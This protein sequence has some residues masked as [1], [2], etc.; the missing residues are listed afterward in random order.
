M[1]PGAVA[2]LPPHLFFDKQ[3]PMTT[4]TPIS[5]GSGAGLAAASAALA[6]LDQ[7]SHT[8]EDQLTS[9]PQADTALLDAMASADTVAVE[10]HLDA[11][12]QQLDDYWQSRHTSLAISMEQALR[13]EMTLKVHE[14]D[15]DA[16]YRVC[17]PATAEP[18]PDGPV[19]AF[20]LYVQFNEDNDAEITGALVMCHG[21]GPTLLWLPGVGMLGFASRSAMSETIA[22]W[23]NDSNLRGTVLR[24]AEQH[25]QDIFQTINADPELFLP[26]FQA[27]DVQLQAITGNPFHYSLDRQRHKQ[28]ADVRHACTTGKQATLV[29][30]AIAMRG[31]L[32]PI[33][34]LELRELAY[35][36]ARQRKQLPHWFRHANSAEQQTC[37]QRLQGYDQTRT[38]LL[39][40]MDGATSPQQFADIRLRT[41]LAT[42]LGYDLAPQD[43]IVNTQRTLPLTGESYTVS[44]SLVQL[45]LYGLHPQDRSEGSAF[46]TQTHLSL[47]DA[48]IAADYPL[49]T[50]TYIARLIDELNMRVTFGEIQRRTFALKHKQQLIRELIRKQLGAL[51]YTAWMQGHISQEELAI[52]ESISGQT[53]DPAVKLQLLRLNG[54]DIPSKLLVLRKDDAQGRPERLV[55]F[56]ADAPQ[57]QLFKGFSNETQLLHELVSWS[58]LAPMSDYLV[59]QVEASGQPR[60]QAQLA[61]LRL[62]PYPPENFMQLLT[63]GDYSQGLSALVSEQLRVAMAE[64][65]RHT[66]AWLIRASTE[67]RQELLALEQAAWAAEEHYTGK[68][69]SQVPEFEAY[70]HQRASQKINQLLGLADGQVD[71]DQIIITSERETLSYTQMLR[72]GYDDSLGLLSAGADTLATF[73]GPEGVDLSLLTPQKVAR[74]VHGKWLADDYI[75]QIRSNLL[76]PES[77]GYDY[78]RQTSLLINQLHMQAAALRSLL[79]GHIDAP[80]YQWLRASLDRLQLNDKQTREDFPL[81][82]LQL[83]IDKPFIGSGL[84]G[85]DQLIVPAPVLIHIET[86]QGCFVVLPTRIRQAALLYTPQAPDGVEFRLFADFVTSLQQPGMVD[87]YKD[88]CRLAAR[89]T[90]SFFLND[91]KKGGANKPPFIPREWFSDL[92]EICYNR[93]LERKIRDVEDT[94]TGRHDMLSALVWTSVELIATAMTLPFPPASFAVGA[95]LAFHDSLRAVT[96]LTNGNHEA[97]SA[98]I[99]TSLFNSL[100]AIGD[101]HSGVKGFGALLHKL[102]PSHGRVKTLQSIRQPVQIGRKIDLYPVILAEESFWLGKPVAEGYAPLFRSLSDGSQELHATGQFARRDANGMW[103]PLGHETNPPQPVPVKVSL[104]AGWPAQPPHAKGVRIVDNKPCID[105]NGQV[106]Q[107]QYDAR[108][109]TWNII[110]PA[111]PYAFYGKKPVHLDAQG[112]W[113]LSAPLRLRGGMDRYSQLPLERIPSQETAITRL[114]D[115]QLPEE[116][117]R[118]ANNIVISK[119]D[120]DPVVGDYFA[121]VYADIRNKYS[122]MRDKLYNDAKAYFAAPAAV[123]RPALP[124]LAAETDFEG[125]VQEC[126][127]QT[128]GLVI[129]EAPKSVV[130]KRLLIEN[131]AALAK[132]DVKILYIEH[133]F[134]DQHLQKLAKYRKLSSN[135]R[136]GSHEIKQ[137]FNLLNDGALDNASREF[138]YYHLVKVAHRNGIEVRPFSSNVSYPHNSHP[139]PGAA[140]DDAAGQKMSN[141]FG[142]QL[143]SGDIQAQPDRRWIALLDQKLANTHRGVPGISELEGA[144]SLRVHGKPGSGKPVIRP[145]IDGAPVDDVTI[146]SD[147]SLEM[148]G[149]APRRAS[150]DSVTSFGPGSKIDDALH[151]YLTD[152]PVIAIDNP[153]PGDHGFRWSDADG[154]QRVDPRHW[155]TDNAPTPLQLSMIDADYEIPALHGETLHD[156]ANFQKRGLDQDYRQA[157]DQQELVQDLFFARRTALHRD[158]QQIVIREL[159]PRPILPEVQPDT[160]PADFLGSLYVHTDGVVI[161]ESHSSI[162]SKKLLIDNLPALSQQNVKT[163]YLEHLLSDLHQA[164]LDRFADTGHMSKR[165]LHDLKVLD[166]GHRTDPTQVYTF[167]KLVI[168]ARE[169]GMEIC[170]IDCVASYYLK[171]LRDPAPT[172]RQQ[173]LSYFA[174]RKITRHQEV[175]GQHKWIALVGNTH[176]NLY[177]KLVPGIAELQGGIGVRV[178]DVKPGAGNTVM[179]DTGE[180][181]RDSLSMEQHFVRGDFR[182]TLETVRPQAASPR[183]SPIEQ[184][185]SRPGMFLIEQGA[186]GQHQVVHRSRDMAIYRTHVQ[187]D[188]QGRVS[189]PRSRWATINGRTFADLD[190]LIT[191]LRQA[192]LSHIR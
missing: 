117:H 104:S 122:A 126:F 169:H 40:A 179:A 52:V 49:L 136:A 17:L 101:L 34:V 30:Q 24:N 160:R 162:A 48:P 182:I 164:D 47:D 87:Y 190:D 45:A 109:R 89:R 133:L 178:V 39:S 119:Y 85:I 54:Q 124:D 8:F 71:P 13:A 18:Q 103:R 145:D 23:L 27:S 129:S 139:V 37:Q 163:L 158:A 192:G 147:F 187:T 138:D 165:L 83:H 102:K 75:A 58:A 26:D 80:Q 99:L 115:Y 61:A 96:A 155:K 159:P 38:L 148:T 132:H 86:V 16:R 105:L 21:Q 149:P 44:H 9:L 90:L 19:S 72:N 7:Q 93:P 156:L 74:S 185:L 191:S 161:G 79:K 92:Q 121:V 69:H 43:L 88:R 184:R 22:S 25:F 152:Q 95:L 181:L 15:L 118:H 14:G 53:S 3:D 33:A 68:S 176:T 167:E 153:Y 76:D 128:N 41:S 65:A 116:M 171:G 157:N 97:A 56:A 78:R 125:L 142:H 50:P 111:N 150:P 31:L 57:A 189:L 62:K 172:S 120:I 10:R 46:L 151:Q 29:N 130:S 5:T 131:M 94:T 67:Q 84:E 91:M 183:T 11:L 134:T 73:K 42:D 70:V 173:M 36:E 55:L 166:R 2:P 146:R 66:P 144:I 35:I 174:A 113:H 82:P 59:Q 177:K 98:Y 186:D 60:L 51:A 77:V 143:I 114:D 63:A 123:R 64:Q 141:F 107:V 168:K 6:S 106:Y 170:A 140:G 81:F 110:D 175:T 112:N 137:H 188:A 12:L 20:S 154:W 100:G 127:K 135:S 4:Y 1:N 108:L 32:G 180:L 28:R